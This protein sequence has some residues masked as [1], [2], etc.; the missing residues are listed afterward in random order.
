MLCKNWLR[1]KNDPDRYDKFIT[2]RKQWRLENKEKIS[3]EK[4]RVYQL[5]RSI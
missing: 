4:K 1:I 3:L 5:K 2:Y